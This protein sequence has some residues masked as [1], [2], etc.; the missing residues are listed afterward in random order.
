LGKNFL[1]KRFLVDVSKE[2]L[3]EKTLVK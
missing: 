1:N 2:N 3:S